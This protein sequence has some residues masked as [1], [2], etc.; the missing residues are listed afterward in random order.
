MCN[1]SSLSNGKGWRAWKAINLAKLFSTICL[2]S[3]LWQLGRSAW[4]A[5]L[6]GDAVACKG[7]V[8]DPIAPQVGEAATRGEF[9][10]ME[11]S[12]AQNPDAGFP[13]NVLTSQYFEESCLSSAIWANQEA[14]AAGWKLDCHVPDNWRHSR[15]GPAICSYSKSAPRRD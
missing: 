6:E 5:D 8:P 14:P 1:M 7:N 13:Y 9:C 3:D 11:R 12:L 4:Q 15:Q 10:V 2:M